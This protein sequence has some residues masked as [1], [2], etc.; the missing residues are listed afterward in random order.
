MLNMKYAV[1]T[2]DYISLRYGHWTDPWNL[3]TDLIMVVN[4]GC[5]R[6]CLMLCSDS[7][8]NCRGDCIVSSRAN[9]NRSCAAVHLVIGPQLMS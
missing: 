9:L 4:H 6:K 1:L 8:D 5:H 2:L 7:M 3:S